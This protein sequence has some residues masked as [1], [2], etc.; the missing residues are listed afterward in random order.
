MK[1][2][3]RGFDARL[4]GQVRAQEHGGRLRISQGPAP[5]S[6]NSWV[7]LSVDECEA[8]GM[9]AVLEDVLT[10][11]ERLLAALERLRAATEAVAKARDAVVAAAI[12]WRREDESDEACLA[13]RSLLEVCL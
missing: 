5:E 2:V 7:S 9:A 12:E 10:P 11:G 13:L 4:R 8:L 3:K 1:R 6:V